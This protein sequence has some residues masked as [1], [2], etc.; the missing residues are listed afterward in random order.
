MEVSISQSQNVNKNVILINKSVG[1]CCGNGGPNL[2]SFP[3]TTRMTFF[4][5]IFF[6]LKNEIISFY[7]ICMWQLQYGIVFPQMSFMIN[8]VISMIQPKHGE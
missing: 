6:N 4:I 5:I 2:L 7:S 8:L 3:K 1:K